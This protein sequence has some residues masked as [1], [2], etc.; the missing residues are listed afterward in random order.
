MTKEKAAEIAKEYFKIHTSTD[1]FHITSD[2]LAFAK[3]G[4][5]LGHA[6]GLK[7]KEVHSIKRGETLEKKKDKKP[8][9]TGKDGKPE[10]TGNG[11]DDKTKGKATS[12]AQL[13]GKNPDDVG[14]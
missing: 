4:N 5:A 14:K 9:N 1:E 10:D 12:T 7:E 2:G 6:T 8:E 13:Y 11:D 3:K